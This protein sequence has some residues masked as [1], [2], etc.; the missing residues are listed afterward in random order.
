MQGRTDSTRILKPGR[1]CWR[2]EHADQLAF[3]ID[4]E[5]FF[6]AFRA[7]TARARHSI[8]II[9]WDIDSRI[10]LV[11]GRVSDQLPSQLADFLR[12]VLDRQPTLHVYV[13]AWDYSLIYALEREWL[14][15]YKLGGAHRRIHVE[16]DSEYPLG[17]SH[18]QKVIVVDDAVAFVGGL[19]LTKARWDT[20]EHQPSD[21]RRVDPDVD[22]YRPLHDVQMMISGK[23][24]AALGELA[25]ARWLRATGTRI[26]PPPPAAVDNLWP[27]HVKPGL[28]DAPV[29]IARTEPAYNGRS[30]IREIQQ[31]FLDSIA[32]ARRFI[33]IETQYLTS[34]L[35]GA[36]L[37]TR[38]EEPHGPEVALVLHQSS[39][40]WLEQ[41]TMDVLRARLLGRLRAADRYGRLGI[42]Y[43]DMPGLGEQSI[44]M[45]SKVMIIDEDLVRI[46]SA[47]LSNRSMGL[48]TEC[49]L[50]VEAGDNEQIRRAIAGLRDQLL[51]EHLNVPP[52]QIAEGFA[53]PGSRLA[54]IERL[55][56]AGRTLKV[57]DGQI[58]TDIDAWMVPANSDLVD[59]DRPLDPEVVA[60]RLIPQEARKPAARRTIAGVL[61]LVIFVG[62]AAAWHWTP[63]Q[64]WLNVPA[65]VQDLEQ[66]K[67]SPSAP[68]IVLGGYVVG[69]LAVMPVTVLIAATVLTFG[70]ALGFVYAFLGMTLSAIVTYGIGR[71]L[72][73]EA[74]RRL[75]GPRI[76]RLSRRLAR[77]GVLAVMTVRILPVAPFTVV[78]VVAGASHI[79]FRDFLLGTII[80][81]LPGLVALSL[82]FDQVWST[83][84]E[85][86]PEKFF[87]LG[88]LLALI[89][90][91]GL[92]LRRWLGRKNR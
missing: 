29:G 80:G 58:P 41:N 2:I 60:N 54:V 39:D 16:M 17:A 70:P 15:S 37:A 9:C 69:G 83:I 30:E 85:P 48:D 63:L 21:P 67:Q 57:F 19:D 46:G 36:A 24:A 64:D 76:N 51:G 44:I 28:T 78:N 90:G 10:R 61:F 59:P 35:I 49:D 22:A 88:A 34:D 77:R 20:R 5:A 1:N 25:R 8:F 75:A 91:G 84:Q 47:N 66:F 71:A 72:G 26:P 27:P 12:T 82:F 42:Y 79:R 86:G 23:A 87:L 52:G 53:G 31:L 43:P 32:A 18:H 92:A 65:L 50:A 68:F 45:H 74:V 38:L 81:E 7:V 14:P 3:L 89:A 33:Y 4:G 73:R 40:G 56:G 13:L 6:Q 62:L 55:R 11:R